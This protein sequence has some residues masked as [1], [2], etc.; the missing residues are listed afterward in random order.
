VSLSKV[1]M[2]LPVQRIYANKNVKNKKKGQSLVCLQSFPFPVNCHLGAVGG[3]L[4]HVTLRS[5]T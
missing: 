3:G 1:E 2:S 4:W 5:V